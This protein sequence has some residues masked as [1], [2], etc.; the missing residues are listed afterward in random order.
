MRRFEL[1]LPQSL[2][3]CL[4]ILAQ[5]G[6][7]ARPVAGGTDLLPQM[8][9]GVLK[10]ALVVDLSG[11]A[12]L[13]QVQN[14]NGL[15][16]GAGV[17]ARELE[18]SPAA[19][20]AYLAIAESAALV[21]SLQVRNL[22]TIGGNLCNAAPS[23]DMAPPLLALEAQAV[24]AGPRGERRVPIADF[25]TTVRKTVLAPDE[26]LVELI[27]PPPGAHSGGQYLRHTPRRELDIAVVGVASQLTLADGRCTKARIALASVA[28]TPVRA[29][30]AE[31][32]LEGR[33]VTP[34][35]I[36]R[37]ATLAIE[38]ANPISDQRGSAEFR[39]HLVRVLTRRTLAAALRRAGA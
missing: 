14:G 23:A 20:G 2:D 39:R 7:R 19:R 11:I 18:V 21:G 24:V 33:A 12:R 27:V 29:V 8:K 35:A 17:T 13:R 1:A 36:E 16:I 32:S 30:A 6:D 22:A 38:A 5:H 34:A 9:N 28:P 4:K 10:P 37:A 31:R 25:F 26:L 3:D 15:R